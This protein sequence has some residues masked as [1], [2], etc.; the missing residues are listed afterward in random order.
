MQ[1]IVVDMKTCTK[2]NAPKGPFILVLKL[3]EPIIDSIKECMKLANIPS[4][5]I[6]AIGAIEDHTVAYYDM[7]EKIYLEDKFKGVYELL[8]MNGSTSHNVKGEMIAH[9]HVMFSGKDHKAYGGHLM[10]GKV[11][12]VVEVT[13][14]PF[15]QEIHRDLDKATG[16]ELMKSTAT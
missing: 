3:G 12:I 10:G 5:S 1:P 8:S 9:L 6:S 11:G 15:A 7:D 2:L 16:L 14:T 4:A 13:V